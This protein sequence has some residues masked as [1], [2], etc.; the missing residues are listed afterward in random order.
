MNNSPKTPI[1]QAMEQRIVSRQELK[2]LMRRSNQPA[3]YWLFGILLLL[4]FTGYCV[5]LTM[6][7]LWVWPAMFFYGIVI[8]HLFSLQHECVHYTVFRTR[9]LNDV[10]GSICGWIIIVPNRF[11]RYEHCNHHTFTNLKSKDP[12][13][14]ELPGTLSEYF[15]YLS[16]WPYWTGK[17]QELSRHVSGRIN[18]AD[19]EFVPREEQSTII[20]EARLMFLGYIVVFGGCVF[21][22]WWAPLWYWWLPLL[23]GEPV[24]R[25][26]RVTEH[27]GRP[28][29]EDMSINT[30]SC[31]VS[32]PWRF[33]CWNMNYH[34]AHHYASSVPF[35]ALP[36]LH[37]ILD[38]QV[39]VEPRGYLGA[40]V[41]I[42]RRILTR[43]SSTNHHSEKSDP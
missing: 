35:H 21:T 27:V 22:G 6:Q 34:A 41:D 5:N 40:H 10:V 39:Y 43:S 11:F 2:R 42:I 4:G 26:I 29:V 24:M 12:E 28:N 7:T 13:L 37:R 3:V 25:A 30:R 32:V 15:L 16:G 33:L 36:E 20:L 31:L 8:V 19:A 14:I 17:V 1:S 18:D 9:W 38:Q 23:L